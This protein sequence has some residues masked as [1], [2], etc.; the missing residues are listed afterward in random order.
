MNET[1]KYIHYGHETFDTKKFEKVE[2][3]LDSSKPKGGLWGCKVST[4]K[5][6]KEWCQNNNFSEDRLSMHFMF[7][8]H[9]NSKIL[10]IDNSEILKTL[11]RNKNAFAS[12]IWITLDF[13]EL[14]KKYDAIEVLI[15]KDFRLY[16]DLL[17]W[18]CD[19]IFIMNPN[20]IEVYES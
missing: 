9:K 11:P 1:I 14:S 12:K 5:G 10:I 18:D 16:H 17:T 4:K 2:N 7:S 3:R 8:L 19:S 6:W 20:I 15:S 13:E